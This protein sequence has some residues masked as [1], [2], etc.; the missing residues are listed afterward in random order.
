MIPQ[1][2]SLE[3]SAQI[4]L[5]KD[6]AQLC[7]SIAE[8][9]EYEFIRS[10]W[11]VVENPAFARE[12]LQRRMEVVF[13]MP[14][15][16]LSFYQE[17]FAL[18]FAHIERKK[19]YLTQEDIAQ[20]ITHI[21]SNY[22][23]P[24]VRSAD[25]IAFFQKSIQKSVLMPNVVETTT[26]PDVVKQKWSDWL[27]LTPDQYAHAYHAVILLWKSIRNFCTTIEIDPDVGRMLFPAGYS[28]GMTIPFPL[29]I[30]EI[31]VQQA[32]RHPDVL[33]LDKAK[34]RRLYENLDELRRILSFAHEK[35]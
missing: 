19:T 24:P 2:S 30:L 13:K 31:L 17:L 21:S 27:T 14:E 11:G 3:Q 10:A 4:P 32:E 5:N 25:V 35:V 18:L 1:F 28:Q 9:F 15:R 22:V 23:S 33:K 12:W 6:F 16:P 34:R 29:R 26:L 20:Y 8:D 7:S